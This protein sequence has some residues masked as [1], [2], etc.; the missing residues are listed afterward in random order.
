MRKT[1]LGLA[2]IAASLF[3]AASPASAENFKWCAVTSG[4]MGAS[5]CGYVTREQCETSVRPE[6]GFCEP[7][8]FYTGSSAADKPVKSKTKRNPS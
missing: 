7:N 8:Q 3:F 6:G 5:N 4:G 2:G 1:L